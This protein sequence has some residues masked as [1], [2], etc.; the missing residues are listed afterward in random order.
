MK[1]EAVLL[2][3]S[4]KF[5]DTWDEIHRSGY[6]RTMSKSERTAREYF[7]LGGR[8][9]QRDIA[10]VLDI[11]C[12]DGSFLRFAAG[13]SRVVFGTEI[14]PTLFAD[15]LREI[16]AAPID[17]ADLDKLPT[18]GYDFVSAINVLEYVETKELA[19]WLVSEM[20]R[21]SKK[22]SLL[23]FGER[24]QCRGSTLDRQRRPTAYWK[25]VVEHHFGP[26]SFSKVSVGP[27][28]FQPMLCIGECEREEST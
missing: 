21:I 9:D 1:R 20:A 12:G 19:L 25:E 8:A 27:E 3:S 7:N 14:C 22:V 18:D 15:P 4:E 26:T 10:S 11:G 6:F 13:R 23:S 2:P 17:I 28:R 5:I 16:S 24:L